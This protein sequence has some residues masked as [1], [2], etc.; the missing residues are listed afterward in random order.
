LLAFERKMA[1]VEEPAKIHALAD[2]LKIIART[3]S[4]K[5]TVIVFVE[6]AVRHGTADP[7]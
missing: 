3:P 4:G 1:R 6:A 5:L 2:S 7:E